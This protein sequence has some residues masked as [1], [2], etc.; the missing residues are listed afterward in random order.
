MTSAGPPIMAFRGGDAVALEEAVRR[1]VEDLVGEGDRSLIVEELHVGDW[2]DDAG[3]AD[4]TPLANAAQT[5]PFLTESRIVVA[6]E[7][8][9]FSKGETLRPLLEYLEQPLETTTVVFVWE[10]AVQGQKLPAFPRALSTAIK[11]AGGSSVDTAPPRKKV[12]AWLDE[13]MASSTVRLDAAAKKTIGD[14]FGEDAS[15]IVG[16]LRTLEG[17]F[18]TGATL[19]VQDIEPFLGDEGGVAP[20]DLTDA[21]DK[22][23]IAASIGLARR[24][25]GGGERHAMQL[26]YSLHSHYQ[27]MLALEGADVADKQGAADLLGI[28]AYPAQKALAQCRRLG[29]EGIAEAIGLL[30][31]AEMDSKGAKGWPPEL[32]VE[33]L[34]ARL[35]Q[36]ARRRR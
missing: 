31:D 24:M 15:R 4:I 13:Q 28:H 1:A 35:A 11:K 27:N 10:R 36:G 33:L 6:R 8:A 12:E 17:A 16:L 9:Y 22:G 18:G 23:D 34:V 26:I 32:V 2:L 3:E 7:T 5:P 20:W 19:S 21:I 14:R 29:F 25:M 30:A